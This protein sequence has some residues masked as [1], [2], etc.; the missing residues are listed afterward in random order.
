MRKIE[1]SAKN[2]SV[3]Y[4]KSQFPELFFDG[5]FENY[6]VNPLSKGSKEFFKEVYEVFD[7]ESGTQNE[8]LM[9]ELGELF[10]A[11][12]DLDNL[13]KAGTVVEKLSDYG[14]FTDGHLHELGENAL[15]A[16]LECENH[17]REEVADV[18]MLLYQTAILQDLDFTGYID[19]RKSQVNIKAEDLKSSAQKLFENVHKF[20]HQLNREKRGRTDYAA[21]EKWH[22]LLESIFDANMVAYFADKLDKIKKYN[23][24]EFVIDENANS[25]QNWFDFKVERTAQRAKDV[26]RR[27]E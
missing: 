20:Y 6:F 23:K 27:E 3:D 25:V 8:L 18:L 4:L 19:S 2:L 10:D 5:D 16:K 26:K 7:G 15:A 12:S 11:M 17:I 1:L 14:K 24:F 9:A 21:D 22:L 13:G